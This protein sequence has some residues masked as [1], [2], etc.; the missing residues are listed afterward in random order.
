[1]RHVAA[2]RTVQ[3]H[4]E[5]VSFKTTGVVLKL[6][7]IVALFSLSRVLTVVRVVVFSFIVVSLVE[8]GV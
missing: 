8:C 4:A 5:R 1:M 7:W 6:C 3:R 2:C